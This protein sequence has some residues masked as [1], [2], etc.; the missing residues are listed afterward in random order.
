MAMRE[1][2]IRFAPRLDHNAVGN[3][4]SSGFKSIQALNPCLI[5]D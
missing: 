4:D 1:F 5:R 3:A 2:Q